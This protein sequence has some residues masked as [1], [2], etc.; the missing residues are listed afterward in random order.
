MS[1]FFSSHIYCYFTA[2]VYI[3]IIKNICTAQFKAIHFELLTYKSMQKYP[4]IPHSM[5]WF[6]D[7]T[8]QSRKSIIIRCR[9]Y[10]ANMVYLIRIYTFYP[11]KLLWCRGG[12]ASPGDNYVSDCQSWRQPRIQLLCKSSVP[13]ELHVACFPPR[14]MIS[15]DVLLLEF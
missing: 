10:R 15:T 12:E 2:C 14:A 11:T 8:S 1:C 5:T 6:S 9:S 13:I 7:V 4:Y 3:V